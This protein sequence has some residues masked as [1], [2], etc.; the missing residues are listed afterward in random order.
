LNVHEV[1]K[2][3][4]CPFNFNVQNRAELEKQWCLGN[5]LA[6]EKNSAMPAEIKRMAVSKD[7]NGKRVK[8]KK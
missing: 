4:T 1:S 8:I 6:H 7:K 2:I 5:L 3:L